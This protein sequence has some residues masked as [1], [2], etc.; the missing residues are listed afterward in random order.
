[1][2]KTIPPH[3]SNTDPNLNNS[4]FSAASYQRMPGNPAQ[5]MQ[6]VLHAMRKVPEIT[7]YF[8]IIKLLTTAMGEVTS[9]Y[10]AHLLDPVVAVALAGIGLVI[11]L[12]L[13]FLVRRYVAWIYWLTIVMVAVFGTMVADVLHVGFGIPYIVSTALFLV[14]L[15]IIFATWYIS[16][17]TLSIHSIYTRRREIFYWATVMATFALGTATGDMTASTLNLGYFA[18]G[19]LFAVLIAVPALAYWLFGLNEI[20]AFWLAYILT[21]PLGAS[22]ADWIGRPQGMSG[23]GLGTGSVSLILTILIIAFVGYLTVTH[24]DSKDSKGEQQ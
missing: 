13:Q 23:L 19:V 11:A 24:K 18:S 22:F 4:T 7:V 12:I 21:R 6:R 20:V 9:D 14:A 16:E 17:K 8:W 5:P 10:L 2:S 1:M 3:P 15:A